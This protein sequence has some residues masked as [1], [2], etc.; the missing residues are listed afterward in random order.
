MGEART[1]N[2]AL[3][4]GR[5]AQRCLPSDLQVYICLHPTNP[6]T[7][8]IKQPLYLPGGGEYNTNEGNTNLRQQ[9]G[10]RRG[11]DQRGGWEPSKPKARSS[12]VALGM[13]Q[14][15]VREG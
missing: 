1:Q 15:I 4:A 10:I 6:G 5:G 7:D 2:L 12:A 14:A 3:A 11:Q 8:V 13:Q 9:N